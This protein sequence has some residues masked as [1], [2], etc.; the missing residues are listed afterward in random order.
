MKKVLCVILSL[1]AVLSIVFV[2][3]P[4]ASAEEM[5]SSQAFIDLLKEREGFTGKPYWDNSHWSIGYGTTCPDNMVDHYNKNPMT[6]EVAEQEMRKS[7]AGFEGVVRRYAEKHGLTLKQNQFDALVS[8]C[9]NCGDSWSTGGSF[10]NA[11]KAGATGSD[12]V[13]AFCLWSKSGGEYI[14]IGRRM[15]E[16][17]MYLNGI[18][19]NNYDYK[20]GTFRCVYLDSGAGDVR[21][22]I[23]G[24]DA[25]DPKPV[26]AEFSKMP[27]GKDGNGNSFTY[28]FAGWYTAKEGGKKVDVLDGSLPHETVLY[29]RWKDPKGNVAYIEPGVPCAP[30]VITAK[31]T[32]NI[33]VGPGTQYSKTGS[34]FK[35]DTSITL[36]RIY[37]K[38]S[39]RWGKFSGGW[40]SL[41]S[42][43]SDFD[44]V[45][46]AS[47]GYPKVGI[48]TSG[49]VNIRTGPSTSKSSVRKTVNG[50]ELTIVEQTFAGSMYWGKLEDGNWISLSYVKF[51]DDVYDD[52]YKIHA[53]VN[54]DGVINKD[55]A[56]YMLR[57]VVYPEKYTVPGNCDVDGSE[58]V[59]KDDA[60]YLLRHVVYPEKYP[61][62][63]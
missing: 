38:G 31:K 62:I 47:K 14:L 15:F 16:A 57:H 43:Y 55:D 8:F 33:R 12:L 4:H 34:S 32:I 49:G 52:P 19:Q 42:D 23:C 29:A 46:S 10:S 44:V 39:T 18:Y 27:T 35:K 3:A 30:L 58:V 40:V 6:E 54:G 22:A 51:A 41:N 25:A 59:D 60:V 45:L 37:E 7:L 5:Q 13:Y 50:E 53:D 28:E 48:A 26:K 2:V 11:I 17:N 36:T 56:I 21:Y 9:Y 24:Y 1:F 20:T 61:L 63:S